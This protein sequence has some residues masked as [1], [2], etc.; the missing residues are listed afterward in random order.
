MANA[1]NCI[2]RLDTPD[3]AKDDQALERDLAR[4]GR[5]G[6]YRGEYTFRFY[7]PGLDPETAFRELAKIDFDTAI[8]QTNAITDKFQRALSTLATADVCLQQTQPQPS[9]RTK[10][11]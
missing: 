1:I 5:S 10:R 4:K 8:S 2:N 6:E 3:F 7:M 11:P 9:N